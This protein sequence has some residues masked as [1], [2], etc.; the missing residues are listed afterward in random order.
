MQTEIL[1]L[2]GVNG[3]GC[4]AKVAEALK[5]I[6]GVRDVAVSLAKSNATV[7][8]EADLTSPQELRAAVKRA[9]YGVDSAREGAC[10]GG[11]GGHH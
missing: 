3:E 9:G 7:Q 5:S 8:F 11:C 4:A 10:C 6:K 1:A 2:T